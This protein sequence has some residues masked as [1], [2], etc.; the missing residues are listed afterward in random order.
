MRTMNKTRNSNVRFAFDRGKTWEF[1]ALTL[2]RLIACVQMKCYL[3]LRISSKIIEQK[4]KKRRHIRLFS[5]DLSTVKW[6]FV[7]VQCLE[8][9][10]SI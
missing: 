9:P 5:I 3:K 4:E 7:F 1:V 8:K 6:V 10:D 2:R